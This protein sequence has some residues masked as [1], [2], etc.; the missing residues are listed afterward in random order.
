[1]EVTLIKFCAIGDSLSIP[2]HQ[3]ICNNDFMSISHKLQCGMGANIAGAAG[4]KNIH[5]RNPAFRK[6][7]QINYITKNMPFQ[8]RFQEKSRWE[9]IRFALGKLSGIM[10]LTLW[11]ITR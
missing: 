11:G 1:M 5:R 4:N 7:S 2:C 8:G 10:F 9:K 6:S 3:I